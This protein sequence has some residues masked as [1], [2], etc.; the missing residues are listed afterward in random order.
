MSKKSK[1]IGKLR[2]LAQ[3]P[4][5][6]I[7]TSD[8]PEIADWSGAERGRFYRPI[9]QQVTLRIDADLLAWFRSKG[10]KYQ[11]RINAALRDYVEHHREP[12]K[13]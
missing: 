7:N 3:Q 5:R 9:K 8:A 10:N 4:D 2:Q 13:G 12:S 1:E 11:T 6:D